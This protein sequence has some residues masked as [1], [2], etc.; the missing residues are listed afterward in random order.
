M[1][2][3]VVGVGDLSAHSAETST[4]L[5]WAVAESAGSGR[6]LVVCYA[7][8]PDS[9]LAAAGAVVRMALLELV[10]PA[11]A[12]AI[13][14]ARLRLGGDRVTV[15]VRAEAP[16]DLLRHDRWSGRSPRRGRAGAPRLA[17]PAIDHP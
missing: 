5:S 10:E 12:R 3:I 15:M 11:L 8:R 9:A 7:C 6:S 17:W 14:A 16:E 1:S 13:A 4:A 2:R